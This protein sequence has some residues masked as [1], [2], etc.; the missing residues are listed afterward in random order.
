MKELLSRWNAA[1]EPAL[2]LTGRKWARLLEKLAYAWHREGERRFTYS[3]G[4]QK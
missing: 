4:D 1:K 2:Y 3:E